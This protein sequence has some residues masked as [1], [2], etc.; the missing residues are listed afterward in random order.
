MRQARIAA[1]IT[2]QE[3]ATRLHYTKSHLSSVEQAKSRP[4]RDL[5]EG[6]ERELNLPTGEL[7]TL[8]EN[9]H[10]SLRYRPISAVD[11]IIKMGLIHI[12]PDLGTGL[13]QERI[14]NSKDRVWLMD[15]WFRRSLL[16]LEPA[17]SEASHCDIRVLLLDPESP[18]TRQRSLDLN[19][20]EDYAKYNINNNLRTFSQLRHKQE[21][22]KI[23]TY[24]VLPSF[25][26]FITDQRALVSYYFHGIETYEAIWLE[27]RI[28]DENSQEPSE[29]G[30][31]IKHEFL[32]IWDNASEYDESLL[33][34]DQS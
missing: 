19:M 18:F 3:M 4:S 17:F 1:K 11:S 12:Y 5:I 20:Q 33:Q 30:E 2:L 26:I 16:S 25:P 34:R 31:Q 7:I 9:Q 24:R 22:I 10:L 6:Y 14:R 8:I 28:P 13:L 23:R 29:F 27:V 21:K 15:T 32:R